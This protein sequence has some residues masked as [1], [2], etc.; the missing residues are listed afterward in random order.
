MKIAI[1]LEYSGIAYSGWQRQKHAIS[2]Q[3]HVEKA[4][5]KVADKQVTVHC[6][7]RT[8]TGVHALH[9]VI[10]FEVDIDRGSYSWVMGGNSNLPNDIGLLWAKVVDD[11]FHA[12]FSATSRNYRYIIFNRQARPSINFG[13][14]SWEYRKLDEGSMAEGAM[15]LVGKHDFSSFRAQACQSKTPVREVTQLQVQRIGEYIIIDI[16]ANAFL[17]HMVRNIV[18]V[19]IETGQG[20]REPSWVAEVLEARNRDVAG[21]TARP[22][23]LYL[24]E[25]DYPQRYA[26]PK[27]NKPAWPILR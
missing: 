13:Y 6:A 23:G 4:L 24:T 22:D 12:R 20:I 18:G 15:H 1:G 19:L 16:T 7:G 2:V 21:I 14:V 9:Q 5:S 25:I 11:S 27:R 17:Q 3:Q 8:D 26:I 10:H